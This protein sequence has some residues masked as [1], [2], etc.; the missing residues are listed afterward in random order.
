MNDFV[1]LMYDMILESLSSYVES[2]EL[3]I[4]DAEVLS[5]AAY[6]ELYTEKASAWDRRQD[7]KFLR[8]TQKGIEISKKLYGDRLS[9]D[10]YK[11]IY[12]N[13]LDEY[14]RNKDKYR[15]AGKARDVAGGLLAAGAIGY[16]VKKL[17][18]KR[19]AK[20]QQEEEQTP[21]SES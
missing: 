7:R 19:K 12:Y 3:D 5:E 20:K 14:K 4:D 9:D 15:A 1:D 16:G 2:G 6:D 13:Q 17:I 8:G 11:Q 18:D 21:E 10:Q